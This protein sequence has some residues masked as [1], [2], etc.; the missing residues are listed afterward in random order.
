MAISSVKATDE[1]NN[2]ST[3]TISLMV[4]KEWSPPKIDWTS[5]DYLNA[6]DYN[7]I[8]NNISHLNAMAARLFNNISILEMGDEKN[9]KSYIYAREVNNIEDSLETLNSETY[10]FDFG[11]KQT[12]R[13][14]GNTPDYNEINRI[15]STSLKLYDTMT[16]HKEA[17]PRLTFTLGGQKGLKV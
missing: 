17:L 1:L 12:Y 11:E 8:I 3:D 9:Y 15:E 5:Q 7:R 14:N 10:S 2:T 6:I 16:A 13:A 4:D